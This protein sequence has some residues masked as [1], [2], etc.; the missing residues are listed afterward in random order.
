MN[1]HCY[2]EVGVSGCVQRTGDVDGE[3]D[4]R[5]AGNAHKEYDGVDHGRHDPVLFPKRLGVVILTIG[6]V[7][8]SG[9]VVVGIKRFIWKHYVIMK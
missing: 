8:E 6:F 4:D 9:C 1:H 2:Y 3:N 7:V 5:V